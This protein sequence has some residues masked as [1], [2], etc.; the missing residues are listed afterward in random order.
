MTRSSSDP[1]YDLDLEIEIT[2]RRLRKARNIA[3]SNSSN[4]IFSSDNSSHVTNTSDSIEYSNTNNFAGWIE[5]NNEKTL[6]ELSTPTRRP[7]KHLKEFYVAVGD[8]RRLHQDEGVRIL[9]GWSSKRLAVLIAS[10]LQ[11]L[12]R[13]EAH[14][15]GKVLSG[16]QNRGH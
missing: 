8:T 3:V 1:L 9:L 7:H 15:L 16:I 14:V 5:N 6:K 13:H 11:H 2:L 12:G 10:S 4:S